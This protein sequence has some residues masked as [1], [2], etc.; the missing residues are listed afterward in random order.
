M[1]GLSGLPWNSSLRK[2]SS[3]SRGPLTAITGIEP[4]I[5]PTTG[6]YFSNQLPDMVKWT[7][8]VGRNGKVPSKGRHGGPDQHTQH[9]C[10]LLIFSTLAIVCNVSTLQQFDKWACLRV[11]ME[12]A[13]RDSSVIG[14]WQRARLSLDCSSNKDSSDSDPSYHLFTCWPSC[15]N[16]VGLLIPMFE[17]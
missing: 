15:W 9:T 7:F 6:P 3:T 1:S 5:R 14:Q 4:T 13:E 8:F 2:T 16:I 17:S 11:P 12:R 10:S